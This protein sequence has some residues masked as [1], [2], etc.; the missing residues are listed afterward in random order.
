MRSEF[1]S[2]QV[3]ISPV[4]GGMMN[5]YP[6]ILHSTKIALAIIDVVMSLSYKGPSTLQLESYNFRAFTFEDSG[7]D[8]P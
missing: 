7:A 8:D 3:P 6:S 5:T 2:S 4:Q 1:N